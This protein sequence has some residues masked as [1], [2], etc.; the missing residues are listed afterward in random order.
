MS[1][2]ETGPMSFGDDWTGVF[3]RGDNAAAYAMVLSN[4]LGNY[5]D[6]DVVAVGPIEVQQL[7]GLLELLNSCNEAN[8]SDEDKAKVQLLQDFEYA[9]Y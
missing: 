3:I 5:K 6:S 8:Q 2:A 4:V 1:R 7:K 9:M